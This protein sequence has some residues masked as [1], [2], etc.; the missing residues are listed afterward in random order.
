VKTLQDSAGDYYL[1]VVNKDCVNP[2]FPLIN[3]YLLST[4]EIRDVRG[5]FPVP[6]KKMVDRI[7]IDLEVL[8]GDARILYLKQ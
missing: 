1:F 2:A 8:P 3:L 5:D 6:F 4:T 7:Q